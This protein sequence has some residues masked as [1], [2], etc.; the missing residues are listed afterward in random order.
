MKDT[1]TGL[2]GENDQDCLWSEFSRFRVDRISGLHELPSVV[3]SCPYLYISHQL[4]SAESREISAAVLLGAEN[5]LD[6]Q[7]LRRVLANRVGKPDSWDWRTN[8]DVPAAIRCR[9]RFRRWARENRGLAIHWDVDMPKVD[10]PAAIRQRNLSG[11][12]RISNQFYQ[13]WQ[14]VLQHR[15]VGRYLSQ[16]PERIEADGTKRRPTILDVGCGPGF[17]SRLFADLGMRCTALDSSPEMIALARAYAG[18]SVCCLQKDILTDPVDERFDGIWASAL[19]LH[20]SR[21]DFSRVLQNLASLL[22]LDG[23]LYV[24]TRIGIGVEFR[25]EGR[26]FFLYSEAELV[27]AFHAV[28]L[29][30]IETWYDETHQGTTGDRRRKGW[31]HYLLKFDSDLD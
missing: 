19:L 26:V 24:S 3:G 10:F 29:G 6:T 25:R 1:R 8:P 16:V 23:V 7:A 12:N 31:I 28:G 5:S 14:G 2:S 11:N 17:Y 22:S 9:D 20:F 15:A 4:A 18:N 13:R 30:A 27:A 21:D